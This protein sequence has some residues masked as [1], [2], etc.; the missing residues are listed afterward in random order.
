MN[1]PH[2]P[3][4]TV[5]SPTVR[6]GSVDAGP[7]GEVTAPADAPR[8]VLSELRSTLGP[9]QPPRLREADA[10]TAQTVQAKS[11]ER[12]RSEN[13]GARYQVSGEIARG[14]MGAIL[15][16]RDIDLGRDLAVKVLLERY[17]DRPDMARRFVE[18]A[19]IGGQLQHPG[20]VPIYDIGRFGSQPFF[21]MKLVKGQTLAALLCERCEPAA[22][23]PRFLSIALQVAHTLAYA[24]ARGVIHRDLKPANI[25]V[26]SFGEVQVMD[27]GLAKVLAANGIEDQEKAGE[28]HQEQENV[29]TV[30]TARSSGSFGS[31]GT[32]TEAGSVLGTPAYMAPEQASGDIANL[33]RRADVFGFGA[34]LCEI[35]TGQ[36]P[37]LGRSAEEV[38]RKAANGDLADARE[39]L[40][41]CGADAELINLTRACL[42]PE[43]VDRPKDAQEVA[44]ALTAHLDGVQD[45]LRKA[46]LAEAEAK[47]K[48]VEE[49][50]RRRL[51]LVLAST[52]LLAMALGGGGLLWVKVERDARQIALSRDVNEALNKAT[53]LREQ[54]KAV[55]A[56]GAALFAQAREQAQRAL[57]LVENGPAESA[58]VAQVKRLQNELDQEEDDRAL[59]AALDTARLAQAETVSGEN[60]FARERAIPL[61]REA[62]R[63]YRLAAGKGDPAAA[64]AR[65][66][67]RPAPVREALL[68]ALD[69]WDDL[70]DNPIYRINEPHREWL[71]AVLEAAEPGDGWSGQ[72][73][74]ARRESDV[75]KR[76]AALDALAEAADVRKIPARALTRL[77]GKLGPAQQAKLLRRAQEQ[78]PADFWLNHDLGWALQTVTPPENDAAVRFLTAAVALRPA[79]PGC[80]VNLGIALRGQGHIDEA[81]ACYQRALELDPNYSAAHTGLSHALFVGGQIEPAIVSLRKAIELAP[82]NT[83]ALSGLGAILCDYKR[84]YD[85]ALE[86]F[87]KA[88]ELEPDIAG[89]HYNLGNA[90]V[91]KRRLDEAIASFRRATELDPNL[92]SAHMKLGSALRDKGRAGEA[93]AS[94]RKAALL[95]PRSA[96]AH[97]NLG[98]ALRDNG[99]IDEAIASFHKAI[100]LDPKFARA[101]YALGNALRDNGQIDEAIASFHRAIECDPKHAESHVNLGALLCDFKRDYAGAIASFRKGIALEPKLVVAHFN[102]GHALEANG[103]INEAIASFREAIELDPTS[104][105]IRVSLGAILCDVKRDYD[106]AIVCFEKAIELDP[107]IAQA[108]GDLGVALNAKGQ[109]QAAM[110]SFQ[111][112][113]ELDPKDANFHDWVAYLKLTHGD[114]AGALPVAET[115]AK[116]ERNSAQIQLNLGRARAGTGDPDGAVAAFSEALRL[117]PNNEYARAARTEAQRDRDLLLRLPDIAAGNAEPKTAREGCRLATLCALQRKRYTTGV[118]LFE[119]AFATDPNLAENMK[120]AHR[121]NAACLAALAAAGADEES[122]KL[123]DNERARLR[124]QALTWLRADLAVWSKQLERGQGSD[125]ADGRS[126]L[127]RWQQDSDLASIRDEAA[128]ARLRPDDRTAFTE[129]WA[130]VAALLKKAQS[131]PVKEFKH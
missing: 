107:R 84:D 32:D 27:W 88:L 39:R 60:R 47:T 31:F 53:V 16:G 113:I 43:A 131:P 25:M 77:A 21:T 37:Y 66:R 78:Y 19:Q 108:H 100:E 117:D 12:P 24:H 106:A 30:R 29:T 38:R 105:K 3:E 10:Q 76:R 11:D 115:A 49:A 95:D 128:L 22:D 118:R 81:I 42:A 65:I 8:S 59:V 4:Q 36:P 86:Y 26:G 35:L 119:A 83:W 82:E 1:E 6:S 23:R 89:H 120:V 125:H 28:A 122:A 116:L 112:A 104:A 80:Y 91:G 111:K 90:L 70:A 124:K 93:I 129:F 48:A 58:L 63:A 40:K 79:S 109:V 68:A 55:T 64:V 57:A 123:D 61:F 54:A 13:A 110:A 75:A 87:R 2:D 20:V 102:L 5:D 92:A 114:P 18:E 85:G 94:S 62:F 56:G 7:T 67:E 52:V 9:L 127:R 33:D 46:E 17:V 14:G 98:N 97:Y 74:T 96:E 69:E 73:R 51:T 99:Q 71:R 15:R 72:V 130:D 45:R 126:A 101:H 103:Q 41:D 50:K 44:E 34:I 121:Y